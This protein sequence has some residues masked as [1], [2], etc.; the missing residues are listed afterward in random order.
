MTLFVK[1]F[2]NA[3]G[4]ADATTSDSYSE[5]GNDDDL[6]EDYDDEEENIFDD[7]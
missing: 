5:D 4:E 6:E 7:F 1:I 3:D 2:I